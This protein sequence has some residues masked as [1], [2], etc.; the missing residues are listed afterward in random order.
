[1]RKEGSIPRRTVSPSY[2]NYIKP[3]FK[4]I[5]SLGFRN[6]TTHAEMTNEKLELV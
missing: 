6:F 5:K 4:R 2:I 3:G 1:M